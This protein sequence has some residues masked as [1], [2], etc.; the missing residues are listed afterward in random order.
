MLLTSKGGQISRACSAARSGRIDFTNFHTGP[1]TGNKQTLIHRIGIY[2]VNSAIHQPLNNWAL[3][4]RSYR[5]SKPRESLWEK[6][7]QQMSH[8]L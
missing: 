6:E 1:Q 5:Q 3:Y 7:I 8:F 4:Q 2:S